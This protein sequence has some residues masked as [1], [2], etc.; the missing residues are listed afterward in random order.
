MFLHNANVVVSLLAGKADPK[1]GKLLIN[2]MDVMA[3]S[4]GMFPDDTYI[5]SPSAGAVWQADLSF[6]L[7]FKISRNL[8]EI[9]RNLFKIS[10]N[11][12]QIS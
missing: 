5:Y 11:L 3:S 10:R 12:F 2:D 7:H 9:S 4:S 6:I 1:K 8:F